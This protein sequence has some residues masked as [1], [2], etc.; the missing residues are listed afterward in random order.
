MRL[1]PPAGGCQRSKWKRDPRMGERE[2]V[3]L[4]IAIIVQW[5]SLKAE[6]SDDLGT[7]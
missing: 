6:H 3:T 4:L 7:L 2:T 1:Q 5:P